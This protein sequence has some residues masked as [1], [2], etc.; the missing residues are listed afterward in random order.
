[1]EK[2]DVINYIY[3]EQE[4]TIGKAKEEGEDQY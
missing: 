1:M 4:M 2:R 3:L